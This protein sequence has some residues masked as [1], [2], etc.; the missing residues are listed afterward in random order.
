MTSESRVTMTEHKLIHTAEFKGGS[1]PR[2]ASAPG[3]QFPPE[4]PGLQALQ[5]HSQTVIAVPPLG[6]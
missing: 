3:W 2:I 1:R 6:P 5:A 4:A